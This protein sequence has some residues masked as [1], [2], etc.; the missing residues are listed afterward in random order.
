[1]VVAAI[2]FSLTNKLLYLHFPIWI[3]AVAATLLVF[4]IM[5]TFS[6]NSSDDP[7]LYYIMTLVVNLLVVSSMVTLTGISN[8]I[9]SSGPSIAF[10][11]GKP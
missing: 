1:M 9:F 6:S 2:L 11:F 8:L 10:S 4:V 7:N 5:S 3:L